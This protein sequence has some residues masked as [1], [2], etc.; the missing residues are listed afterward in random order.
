M[1]NLVF[2]A[3]GLVWLL[4]HF[5]SKRFDLTLN[6]LN[7]TFLFLGI[8][9]HW[10]PARFLRSA[11]EGGKL[12]FGVVLQFPFY[13]GM[14]G[15]I[16]SSGLADIVGNWFVSISSQKTYPAVVYWYSGLVNYF[17]PS[18]GSKWAIEAPY[19][20]AAAK[21]L[22]VPAHKVVMA[23]AW[24][25]MATDLI[26]PFW[27]IPLLTVAKLEFKDIMGYLIIIFL[28]YLLLV[29]GA[30]LLFPL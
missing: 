6:V 25:D 26:Q 22:A 18:G 11:E 21:S 24:G 5:S 14:Y 3:A 30:F 13:A 1:V 8:L 28:V 12:I 9:L 27:A 17:V 7:F 2:A 16:K 19:I 29:S 15:I 23:Y 20:L 4:V 10:T